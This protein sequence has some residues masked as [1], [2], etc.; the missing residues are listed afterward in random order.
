VWNRLLVALAV[1]AIALPATLAQSEPE[2]A[3]EY[4]I[5]IA[6]PDAQGGRCPIRAVDGAD[7][8]G[9]PA[10]AV[11]PD[12]VDNMIFAS[13]HGR[14]GQGGPSERSR[15]GQAYTT[16]TSQ[17]HGAS[18]QDNPY[19]PPAA[20]GSDAYGEHP[21]IT[22]DPYGH[23]F[24]G[25][26]YAMPVYDADS[27][28]TGD[29]DFVL[30]AQKFSSLADINQNQ[31]GSGDYNVQYITPVHQGNRITETWFLHNPRTDNMTMVW[32]E[33]VTPYSLGNV[34]P[35]N[36]TTGGGA[37]PTFRPAASLPGA[38]PS[39]VPP[40]ASLPGMGTGG[41]GT[42][43]STDAS[44][45]AQEDLPPKSVI[46][47]VWSTSDVSGK[48]YGQPRE[49]AIGPCQSSTNPVLSEGWLYIG[50]QVAGGE[51]AFPWNEDAE[52]GDI[53]MFRMDPDGGK[54]QYLGSAPISGGKPKLGVRS[55]GRMALMTTEVLV[56][57]TVPQVRLDGVYGQ[58]DPGSRR[59][60]WG[61]VQKYGKELQILFAN[62]QYIDSNIQDMIYR[63]Y[64][65]VVHMVFKRVVDW[66]DWNGAT[67]PMLYKAVIAIDEHYGLLD[68]IDLNI[69]VLADRMLDPILFAQPEYVYNDI[70]DDFLELPSAP[71]EYNGRP[72]GDQYQRE[73]YAVGNYGVVDFAEVIEITELRGPAVVS[74][75]NP[76]PPPNPAPSTASS[77]AMGL[78]GALTASSIAA[79][80]AAKLKRKST[81]RAGRKE[82][83]R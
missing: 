76:P 74:L 17:N 16:F 13:L 80:S 43:P 62:T 3:V 4:D 71:Y 65:G 27:Q 42:T 57:D 36:A 78:A 56:Y 72:L 46:G 44:S 40:T 33:Q 70:S 59:V 35:G 37:L 48:Y 73:F 38:A 6:C 28:Q 64:S 34:T 50:C 26:L 14:G 21:A 69:G 1:L 2:D 55:D 12:N 25:S 30:A 41:A 29:Y 67:R 49:W 66:E 23:V 5:I 22:L 47:V 75:P 54:P 77:L 10:I 18:W 11:D 20:V 52:P 32:N 63:E 9:D 31:G 24:I 8:M 39:G 61:E 79:G 19:T 51:G 7:A 68:E 58:Y 83:T 53:E 45:S 81:V 82:R 15:A 60:A